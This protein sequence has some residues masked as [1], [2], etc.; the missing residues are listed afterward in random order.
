MRS[1]FAAPS[2]MGHMAVEV[3][4]TRRLGEAATLVTIR[5]T[6]TRDSKR[7][8]GGISTQLWEPC[9][10]ALRITFEHAS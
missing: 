5:W 4:G 8:M 1:G 6:I 7:L 10:G 2:S 3:L 9:A